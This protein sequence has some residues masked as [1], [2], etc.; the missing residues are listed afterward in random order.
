MA[1]LTGLPSGTSAVATTTGSLAD[2]IRMIKAEVKAPEA[3]EK[4][5]GA[6]VVFEI[7]FKT[8]TGN[9]FSQ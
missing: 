2:A 6:A 9:P 1:T 5:V 3:D 4:S 8:Q 7:D